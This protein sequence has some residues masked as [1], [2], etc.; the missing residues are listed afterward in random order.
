MISRL[1]IAEDNALPDEELMGR[2]ARSDEQAFEIL[3]QRHQRR[4]LN[5]IIVPSENG[6]R[7]RTWPRRFFCG[8]GGR[9]R[10]T[11]QRQ[12][13]PPGTIANRKTTVQEAIN[14]AREYP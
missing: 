11:N 8:Y 5:L 1:T 12:N 9:P 2:I 13:S 10:T 3:V 7:P 14:Y 4:I 6:C